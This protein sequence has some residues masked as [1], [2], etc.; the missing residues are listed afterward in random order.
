MP[1]GNFVNETLSSCT[2]PLLDQSLFGS[3]G[4]CESSQGNRQ[5]NLM[6][7]RCRSTRTILRSRI[8]RRWYNVLLPLSNS[9]LAISSRYVLLI[10]YTRSGITNSHSRME[11]TAARPKLP[12]YPLR[13]PLLLSPPLFRRPST[14]SNPSALPLRR[15]SLPGPLH[16]AL[17]CHTSRHRSSNM[18]R[19][20][21][22]K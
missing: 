18:L 17:I 6:L 19:R 11:R 15:P 12:L 8:L 1:I 7:M 13:N 22:A 3:T 4:G 16:I 10:V 20:Y 2:A 9:G 14:L 5:E 21:H